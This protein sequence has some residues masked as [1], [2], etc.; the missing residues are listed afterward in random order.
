MKIFLFDNGEMGMQQHFSEGC[1]QNR[2]PGNFLKQISPLP[3]KQ[4]IL[5]PSPLDIL[6]VENVDSA[7]HLQFEQYTT[8]NCTSKK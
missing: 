3:L 4:S 5:T 6:E 8:V 1:L 7:A 2:D